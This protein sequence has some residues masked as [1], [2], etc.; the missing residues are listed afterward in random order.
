MKLT[1]S[2]GQDETKFNDDNGSYEK[3]HDPRL[4]EFR[5]LREAGYFLQFSRSQLMCQ[6]ESLADY[7]R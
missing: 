2:F 4:C 6:L 3:R 1:H 7:P 5:L